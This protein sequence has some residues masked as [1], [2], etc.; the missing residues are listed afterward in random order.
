MDLLEEQ[1]I[2]LPF[3]FNCTDL[4]GN[5]CSPWIYKQAHHFLGPGVNKGDGGFLYDNKDRC[6]FFFLLF[7]AS[8]A[9]Y[10]S[11]QTRGRIRATGAVLYHSH[12]NTGSWPHLWPTSQLMATPDPQPT[13]WDQGLNPHPH[14]YLS[15]SFL[16]C[17]NGN[18]RTSKAT[19][20]RVN[21][22]EFLNSR[23]HVQGLGCGKCLINWID[24]LA[25]QGRLYCHLF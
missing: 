7:R 22:W 11:S 2:L 3:H 21:R 17:H 24:K 15:D 6:F 25:D 18:S 13:E 5:L 1:T 9:A 19:L 10:G 23:Y 12:S 14:G 20:K 4:L 8:P 16:L